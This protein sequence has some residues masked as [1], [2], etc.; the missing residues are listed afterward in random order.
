MAANRETSSSTGIVFAKAKSEWVIPQRA[1]PGRKSS[2]VAVETQTVSVAVLFSAVTIR[3]EM[4][5]DTKLFSPNAHRRN[6]PPHPQRRL[7]VEMLNE[8][9]E[10]ARPN[11]SP[12]S[13]PVSNPSKRERFN[14]MSPFNRRPGR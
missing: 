13:K 1:K 14:E 10:N 9:F 8:P 3:T 2:K 5:R 12:P 6:N 7:A 4:A 11:T